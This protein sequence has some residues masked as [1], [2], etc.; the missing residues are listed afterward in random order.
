[1]I[2]EIA[3]ESFDVLGHIDYICRVAPYENSEIDEET[4]KPEVDEVLKILLERG[5]ILELNT[6]RL[7][8]KIAVDGLK[9]LYRRYK[10][11]GGEFVTIGSDAHTVNAVGANF[12]V[13]L[14]FVESLGLG[15]F[16]NT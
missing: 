3:V 6:R 16:P 5:K 12:D 7:N 4:F 13:A 10:N 1:M 9:W 8:N 14:N 11:L 2:E 15:I